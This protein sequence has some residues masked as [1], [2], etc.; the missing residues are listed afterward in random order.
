ANYGR[1][2]GELLSLQ[3]A[4]GFVENQ[5][6]QNRANHSNLLKRK[7]ESLF[8]TFGNPDSQQTLERIAAKAAHRF[9]VRNSRTLRLRAGCV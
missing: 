1:E 5:D 6:S 9:R 3:F 8:D 7:R 2:T 4:L